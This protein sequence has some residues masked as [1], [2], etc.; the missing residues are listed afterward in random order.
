M[1]KKRK[2]NYFKH[3]QK[4]IIFQYHNI[5]VYD[6]I[7]GQINAILVSKNCLVKPFVKNLTDLKHLNKREGKK[8]EIKK[9]LTLS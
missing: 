6:C 3:K 4:P 2:K 9:W 1:L 5:T 7:F 8:Y